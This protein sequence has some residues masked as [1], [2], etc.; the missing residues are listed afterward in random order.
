MKYKKVPEK[1]LR[2]IVSKNC[3]NDE[4]IVDA[5]SKVFRDK[6]VEE[7]F[8]LSAYEDKSLPIG[9]GQTISKPSTVAFMT[10]LLELNNEDI[11]LEIGT[12]SGFQTAILSKLCKTVYT[13]ERIPQLYLRASSILKRMH[14]LN[15][16]FKIDNGKLGWI[17]NSPFDKII[18]TAGHTVVPDELV[19]QLKEGGLIVMPLNEKITVIKKIDNSLKIL[20]SDKECKFVNFVE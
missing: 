3:F 8:M 15:I 19:T 12:G 14:C 10:Y 2:E 6:F 17:E 20:E 11:V 18:I 5:F 9:F 13:V 7:A 16:S 1:Y 4:R